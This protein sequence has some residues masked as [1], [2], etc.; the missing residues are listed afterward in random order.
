MTKR[1]LV[2][3]N[4]M[5]FVRQVAAAFVSAGHDV[6][7]FSNAMAALEALENSPRPDLLITRVNYGST[8]STGSH[9]RA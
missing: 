1:I 4:D 2:V 9:W 7:T 3:H 6:L 8:R 5:S